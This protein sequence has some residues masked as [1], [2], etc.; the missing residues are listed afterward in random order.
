MKNKT[1]THINVMSDFKF[2]KS[3]LLTSD[4]TTRMV[5]LPGV[6]G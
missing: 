2:E 5:T 6:P 3:K 4:V 1:S